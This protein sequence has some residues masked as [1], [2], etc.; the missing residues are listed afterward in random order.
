MVSDRLGVAAEE[1][2]VDVEGA[3]HLRSSRERE[4]GLPV[5][6]V[7]IAGQNRLPIAHDVDVSRATS[8]GGEDFQFHSFAGL[9]DGAVDPQQDLVGAFPRLQ[10]NIGCGTDAAM[11]ISVH[12][13]GRLSEPGTR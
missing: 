2:G 8:A 7:E 9:D 12:A 3:R 11:I 5:L 10:G 13:E 4:L 6:Q 1:V